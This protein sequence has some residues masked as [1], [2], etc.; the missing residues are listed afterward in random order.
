MGVA[1]RVA[2]NVL[3]DVG[4]AVIWVALVDVGDDWAFAAGGG[5]GG[6]WGWGRWGGHG[7]AG[8]IDDDDDDDD[9]SETI[10]VWGPLTYEW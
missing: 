2:D 4:E 10:D 8:E 3:F 6:W 7:V 1:D 9:D 5:G